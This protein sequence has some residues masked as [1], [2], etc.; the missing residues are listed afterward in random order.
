MSSSYTW[1]GSLDITSYVQ[2]QQQNELSVLSTIATNQLN[3]LLAVQKS[4]TAQSTHYANVDNL[5]ASL[6]SD[7]T[8]LKNLFNPTPTISS[9]NPNLVTA[10]QISG[11]SLNNGT[12]TLIV[13]TLA[14]A[15]TYAS[16]NFSSSSSALNSTDS[17]K[18]QMGA[19]GPSFTVNASSTDTLQTL[20]NAIN[21]QA[22]SNNMGVSASVVSPSS[23]NYELVINSTQTG[24]ANAITVTDTTTGSPTP[25]NIAST[26]SAQDATFTYDGINM[27]QSSNSNIAI[28][29]L[30]VNLLGAGGQSASLT[31]SSSSPIGSVVTAMQTVVADYNNLMT[32]LSKDQAT[33]GSDTA[34]SNIQTALQNYFIPQVKNGSGNDLYSLGVSEQ[35]DATITKI[36]VTLANGDSALVSPSGLVSLNTTTLTNMLSSNYA[37]VQDTLTNAT[38]GIM[39]Q[40]QSMLNAGGAVYNDLHDPSFGAEIVVQK[41]LTANTTQQT[42]I[43]TDFSNQQA[44]LKLQYGSLLYSLEQMQTQSQAL[45]QEMAGIG[46][47]ST[48]H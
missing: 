17:I 40:V 21:S 23:G 25:L 42:K 18:V 16:G 4:L 33:E 9:S 7:I 10:T 35:D 32:E 43:Q 11:Q 46:I 27:T 20:A 48:G 37:G 13:N 39:T 45:S 38:T 14:K 26:Q 22:S 47:G 28:G 31:V 30:N 24:T 29:G 3:P 36:P 15:T 34:L 19:S 1:F 44:A 5:L 8:S 41:Q 6:N 2:Q 12:H